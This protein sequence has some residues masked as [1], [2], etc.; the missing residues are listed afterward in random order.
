MA[1][2][3]GCGDAQQPHHLLKVASF[4]ANPFGLTDMSGTVAEW[5]ADCWNK[6]YRG[7]PATNSPWV[8]RNCRQHVLRGGSWQ[9]DASEARS[10]SR[11]PYDTWVR[12]LT[13]G[14]RPARSDEVQQHST[15]KL[16]QSKGELR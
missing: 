5:V 8:D 9:N 15:T 12:Y 16:T 3:R 11:D 4:P 2:C 10:A 7:A 13:H 14:F 6:N 1:D